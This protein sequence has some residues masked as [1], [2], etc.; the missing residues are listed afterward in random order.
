MGADAVVLKQFRVGGY[1]GSDNM[2]TDEAELQHHQKLEKLCVSTRTGKHNQRDI[3]RGVEGYIVMIDERVAIAR[4]LNVTLIVPKL[5]K[6]SLLNDPRIAHYT[7]FVKK[8]GIRFL[9]IAKAFCNGKIWES[10]A[11]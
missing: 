2:V 9:W 11:A 6:T 3:V 1:E 5:Y 4:H 8:K 10:K 7:R